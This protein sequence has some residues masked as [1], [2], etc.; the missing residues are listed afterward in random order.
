[1]ARRSNWDS[2]RWPTQMLAMLALALAALLAGCNLPNLPPLPWQQVRRAPLPAAQ[3][4]VHLA[5]WS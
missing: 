1:M 3:Q 5:M 4:T 2:G